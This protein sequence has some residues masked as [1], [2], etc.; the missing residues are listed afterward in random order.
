M[1]LVGNKQR[2][3]RR[4]RHPK[5]SLPSHLRSPHPNFSLP[6]SLANSPNG[7]IAESIPPHRRINPSSPNPS[8]PKGVVEL[9]DGTDTGPA[10]EPCAADE[11]VLQGPPSAWDPL[12]WLGSGQSWNSYVVD[13]PRGGQLH[14]YGS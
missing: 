14:C 2:A 7:I 10:T 9:P 6:S 5:F 8:S 13:A 12:N 1:W 4:H 3:P 11:L